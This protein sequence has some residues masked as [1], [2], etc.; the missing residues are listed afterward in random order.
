MCFSEPKTTD[1]TG[2]I[3]RVMRQLLEVTWKSYCRL[4]TLSNRMTDSGILQTVMIT[5]CNM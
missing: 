4:K 1:V 3:L 5:I 2:I